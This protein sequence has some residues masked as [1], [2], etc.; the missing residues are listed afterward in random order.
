ML[1]Y[2][3]ELV[4]LMP[5]KVIREVDDQI[6][7]QGELPAKKAPT[8]GAGQN[9]GGGCLDGQIFNST[10]RKCVDSDTGKADDRSIPEPVAKASS[11]TGGERHVKSG[12]ETTDAET[13]DGAQT[14]DVAGSELPDDNEDSAE[15]TEAGGSTIDAGDDEATDA[16]VTSDG[17]VTTTSTGGQNGNGNDEGNGDVASEARRNR[18]YHAKVKKAEN[19]ASRAIRTQR[20]RIEAKKLRAQE[21]RIDAEILRAREAAKPR[22]NVM[23]A[24]GAFANGKVSAVEAEVSKP[25]AWLRAVQRHQNVSPAYVWSI[26]KEKIFEN[27]SK[28]GIRSF[29]VNDNEIITQVP[30]VKASEVDLTSVGG[31]PTADFMRIMS[32]QV[33]V[34]PS[35]KVVTPIRQFC[36]T[37]I[38]PAGTKEAFFFDFGAVTFSPIVEADDA[39]AT[40][41]PASSPIIRSQATGANPRGTRITIGYQQTEESPIDIVASANR[42]FALESINDESKQ[43]MTSYNDDTAGSGTAAVR[44]AIGAG[45]KDGFW[46]DGNSGA[47]ITADASGLGVIKYQGLL[48]AKGVIQDQGLDDSNLITYTSGK[49]IRDLTLDADLDSYIGFSRPAIIT[50]ATVERIAGTNLVR[51]SAISDSVQTSPQG[52]RS[53]MFIPNVAFGLVSGRDLTMEA[54]RRNELQA[55]HITGTQR[56]AGAVKNVE[57]T[58]RISHI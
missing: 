11:K 25:S 48:N 17:P 9:A 37:K 23:P 5:R 19:T 3:S 52:K 39:L 42:A 22:L 16:T 6:D 13:V 58:C 44:K 8:S 33:L 10:T 26:N 47:Q 55:I 2:Q 21:M 7:Y 30:K 40:A 38:L 35:G 24:K 31:P 36:E 56:I 45:V 14:V 49:A 54:Q 29:D 4:I 46:V 20:A 50:E 15:P 51:S 18:L 57:A 1:I 12:R 32:E 34:L 41:T 28:K 53:V 27:Y 43:I